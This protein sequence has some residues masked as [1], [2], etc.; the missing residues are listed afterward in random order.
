[1]TLSSPLQVNNYDLFIGVDTSK[2]SYSFTTMGSDIMYKTKT[3]PANPEYLHI[4]TEKQFPGK[5]IVFAYEAGPTGYN[6]YDYLSSKNQSCIVVA[7]NSVPKASNERVKN[8]KIDSRKLAHHLRAG[9]LHS[10]RIPLGSY[11]ELRHLVKI[12]ENYTQ[13]SRVAKQRI[14]SLLLLE[15]LIKHLKDPSAKWSNRYIQE[16]K[17]IPSTQA[18]KTRLAMLIADLEYARKQILISNRS[19]RTFVKEHSD[20]TKHVQYLLS[21][22]GIGFIIAVSIL[23]KIGDPINLRDSRELANFIGLAPRE[24][25]TGDTENR[26]G[27]SHIGNSQL[28]YLLIEA[29]WVAIRRDKELEQFYHRIKRRHHPKGASQKA[30]V[31]VARKLSQRI[32]R[33]LKDQ[34][35]YVIH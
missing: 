11:R 17:T 10:I 24:H 14:K 28:R 18:V 1:M 21:L 20:I 8:N 29:A 27:I 13:N 15:N 25:S 4:Y 22:P 9:N 35:M 7:P 19:L 33:V 12:R 2:N 32:Y 5:S 6:L 34:R 31:A 3:I 30:I 26:G 23:G 16:L